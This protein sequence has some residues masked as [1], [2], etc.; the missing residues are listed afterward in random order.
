[1]R[2]NKYIA[3]AT[4]MSRRSADIAISNGAVVVNGTPAQPGQDISITDSVTLDGKEIHLPEVFTTILLNKPTGYVCSREGQ[5]SKTVYDLLPKELN[6][7]KTVGRLDKDSSGLLL[8]TNDGA[9]A[10]ML[11]HPTHAKTKVYEV[12]LNAPLTKL[13]WSSVHEQGLMLPDGISRLFLERLKPFDDMHWQVTMHEGRNRQ[14]R[15][16][17]RAIG[18][19]VVSLHRIQFG[20]YTLANI[21]EGDYSPISR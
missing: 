12:T 19:S 11:T 7:L 21:A 14:I 3:L 10:N 5:G 8:L 20:P 18:Y 4:G 2:I 13:D 9:L 15:R 17:F 6:H 1:M 16:T